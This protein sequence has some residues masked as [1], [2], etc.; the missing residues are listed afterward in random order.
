MIL[1]C[2]LTMSFA[3]P[4][5]AQGME[6]QVNVTQ[7]SEG[8]QDQPFENDEG[9]TVYTLSATVRDREGAITMPKDRILNLT[10]ETID[11]SDITV[12]VDDSNASAKKDLEAGIVST[13]QNAAVIR[14]NFSN[15]YVSTNLN[16]DGKILIKKEG[17]LIKTIAIAY[18]TPY[19]RDE[20]DSGFQTLSSWSGTW[21]VLDGEAYRSSG[22]V[23]VYKENAEISFTYQAQ[24][25]QG[26]KAFHL[27]KS[28]N[29][30]FSDGSYDQKAVNQNPKGYNTV[31][32][33]LKD[34]YV[35][36]L[37]DELIK[38]LYQYSI[39]TKQC[40]FNDLM[41]EYEDGCIIGEVTDF[42]ILGHQATLKPQD[43]MILKAGVKTGSQITLRWNRLSDISG[44]AI[45]RYDSKTQKYDKIKNISSE[46]SSYT[47]SK[48]KS[49]KT[50]RYKIVP[51]RSITYARAGNLTK[52][53]NGSY[54]NIA[55]SITKP[56]TPV[57]R[58]KRSGRRLKV[59]IKK[60]S[61]ASGYRIYLRKGKSGKYK[62]V[63]TYTGSKARTYKSGKLKRNKPYYVKVRAYKTFDKKKYFGT[64]TKTKK[65]KTPKRY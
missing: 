29:Y 5:Y 41:V 14:I 42:I 22:K 19:I 59:K 44:Y 49:G 1:V 56:A 35:K 13:S 31:K 45:Y 64:Y 15:R 33:R 27:D 61:G 7:Q 10:S 11:L 2:I 16:W 50:Y 55:S 57:V 37:K 17:K 51:Y 47:D 9:E 60:V 18:M 40:T 62:C 24:G 21:G 58:V 20:H 23:D 6:D 26:V 48:L 38:D 39:D 63:K 8:K 43:Q 12:E 65:I 3:M 53:V 46:K 32:L 25:N 30:T 4:V 52:V 36:Q 34:T 54:S 28:G